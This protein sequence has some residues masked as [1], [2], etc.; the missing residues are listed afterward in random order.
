MKWCKKN[1]G[2]AGV[3][4]WIMLTSPRNDK[5][6][7]IRRIPVQP[8]VM[9]PMTRLK[10]HSPPSLLLRIFCPTGA[11]Q[12]GKRL[13]RKTK[14]KCTKTKSNSSRYFLLPLLSHF[15]DFCHYDVWCSTL[16]PPPHYCLGKETNINT[17]T[18]T[19]EGCT[20]NFMVYAKLYRHKL[21]L[22][23]SWCK[24]QLRLLHTIMYPTFI[25]ITLWTYLSITI[26]NTMLLLLYL[27]LYLISGSLYWGLIVL[28]T[29]ELL[30]V[31]FMDTMFQRPDSIASKPH[32][33]LSPPLFMF[34]NRY[35]QPLSQRFMV[36]DTI[37]GDTTS[38]DML[39]PCTTLH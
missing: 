33:Q 37:Q 19:I 16:Y 38:S 22:K 23:N 6:R 34:P 4:A 9:H 28:A 7:K 17:I 8:V 36:L 20:Q 3:T 31:E 24:T 1:C 27:F 11:L 21:S 30:D 14:S 32:Q 18:H 25:Y 12:P 29:L 10:V 39:H 2:M 26:E 13:D 5:R 35:G 15:Q